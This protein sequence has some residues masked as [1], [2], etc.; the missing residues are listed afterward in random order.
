MKNRKNN[1]NL[2]L[3]NFKK[4]FDSVMVALNLGPTKTKDNQ[5]VQN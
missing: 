5:V 4:E 2:M 3:R 1:E